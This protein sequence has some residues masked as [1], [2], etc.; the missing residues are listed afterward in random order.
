MKITAILAVAQSF[1]PGEGQLF[2]TAVGHVVG[3][4]ED[5][6]QLWTVVLDTGSIPE[7]FC[8]SHVE[9]ISS[10]TLGALMQVGGAHDLPEYAAV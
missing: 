1:R 2:R 9:G 8:N 5:V 4:A 3:I 10:V 7:T 6:A